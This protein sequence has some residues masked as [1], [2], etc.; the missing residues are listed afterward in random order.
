MK[1]RRTMKQK[2]IRKIVTGSLTTLLSGVLMFS[3]AGAS[4]LGTGTAGLGAGSQKG[5][6]MGI[7]EPAYGPVYRTLKDGDVITGDELSELQMESEYLLVLTETS[8][9]TLKMSGSKDSFGFYLWDTNNHRVD[10]PYTRIRN[11]GKLDYYLI[12]GT[13]R[14]RFDLMG[15]TGSDST[16]ITVDVS[17]T[18]DTYEENSAISDVY[19][20]HDVALAPKISPGQE[21][22]GTIVNGEFWDVYTITNEYNNLPMTISIKDTTGAGKNKL[23]YDLYPVD[24]TPPVDDE[25]REIHNPHVAYNHE[26]PRSKDGITDTWNISKGTYN[27][28]IYN[29][30]LNVYRELTE[31][32][33]TDQGSTYTFS[34]DYAPTV[35]NTCYV[36]VGDS[37]ALWGGKNAKSFGGLLTWDP[38]KESVAKLTNN[39]PE[40]VYGVRAGT[41]SFFGHGSY[42]TVGKDGRKIKNYAYFSVPTIVEYKDVQHGSDNGNN[43]YFYDPVYWATDEGITGGVKDTD[44]VAR[45]FN[46]QGICNRAQMVSFLWRM[47]GCPE[48]KKLTNFK[49]VSTKAYYYK[50]VCWAQ[51]NGITGGYSDGTFGPDNACTRGQAVTFLYRMAGQPKVTSTSGFKDVKPGTYYYNAVLWAEKAGITGGYSDN[52]FRPDNQC[53]RAQ[54]VTFLYRYNN[55]IN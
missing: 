34:V 19:V 35:L 12:S 52:T 18:H 48:P 49:D 14:I 22:R 9:L 1:K 13:Y 8:H 21:I 37:A 24:L 7:W 29:G 11:G 39:N 41:S 55:Y 15:W 42:L 40:T 4:E 5:E 32:F 16:R 43:P 25:N 38:A 44:G 51:E 53:T 30:E 27:L 6:P 3:G 17:S 23:K 45:N 50:A 2:T 36:N 28:V 33:A 46:P 20:S 47:A 31:S 26:I 54:M 10:K